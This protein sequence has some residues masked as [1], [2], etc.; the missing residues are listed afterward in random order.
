[1]I[2]RGVLALLAFHAGAIPLLLSRR[3]LEQ[4]EHPKILFATATAIA[5]AAI[6]LGAAA[7]RRAGRSPEGGQGPGIARDPLALG[8]L[9][10]LA[11]ASASA[12]ASEAPRMSTLGA[13]PSWHGV[14]T[15]AAYAALFFATRAVVAGPRSAR[16]LLF[17]PVAA[18]GAVAVHGILE[19][20]GA[21]PL[22][23]PLFER[24]ADVPRAAG[25]LGN[26]TFL[27]G[28]LAAALP[29]A[30]YLAWHALE[31]R[32]RGAAAVVGVVALLSLAALA[33]SFSRGP[34]LAAG[35]ALTLLGV[36]AW[37]AGERRGARALVVS[38]A[39]CVALLAAIAAASGLLRPALEQAALRV[40]RLAT[41]AAEV[42][43]LLWATSARVFLDHPVLGTGPDALHLAFPRYASAELWAREP[44]RDATRAHNEILHVAATQGTVGLLALG[45]AVAGL[46]G[47]AR[48]ASRAAAP[49]E[50]I[51]VVSVAASLLA[52]GVHG[53][54]GFTVAA[55][56]SLFALGAGIL[57]GLARPAP[58]PDVA[59]SPATLAAVLAA[60]A[61][62][63]AAALLHSARADAPLA[64]S[65]LGPALAAGVALAAR[66]VAREATPTD[67][68][69]RAI[70]VPAR[71]P[72]AADAGSRARRGGLRL[73]DAAIG[74]GAA[75]ALLELVLFPLSASR[76]ARGGADLAAAGRPDAAVAR[77]ERA[78]ALE[79]DEPAY[80]AQLGS[81]YYDL[82]LRT[83]ALPLRRETFERALR[84]FE[85]ELALAPGSTTASAN[86]AR[87]LAELAYLGAP[88]APAERVYAVYD[89]AI[90][91]A[92]GQ[93]RLAHDA[94]RTALV[95]GDVDRAESY[96][97]HALD[98]L[99]DFAPGR[100]QLAAAAARRGDLAR[101][102]RELR[103]A[104]EQRWFGERDAEAAARA[105]LARLH[106]AARKA[107]G[108]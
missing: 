65:L 108:R 1:M 26:A 50:R 84:A 67:P 68:P 47:T 63:G 75:V 55:I 29:L 104:L 85:R 34:W 39:A 13:Y 16:F 53:L 71:D 45:L 94:A 17:S 60:A 100:A 99:P 36:G 78:V 97:A 7:S 95:L 58:R 32:R 79:P 6:A 20:A 106:A 46:V 31:V 102:E 33:L 28:Y 52:V 35:A 9:A 105:D 64:A 66:E 4:F 57:S 5:L 87:A 76:I 51:L 10:L 83:P 21:G 96:A 72:R 24:A 42:R 90:A 22:P 37:R 81:A 25:P 59:P 86:V 89:R 80:R 101:A 38:L 82:A 8:A 3:M 73:A 15:F 40:G 18:A 92:P 12:A 74:A 2:R 61:A 30:A 98:A 93:I 103:T 54:F 70:G 77:L 107:A 23:A 11:S 14:L 62:I 88:D 41:P 43:T 49:S 19:S 56:G 27:G 69:R 48:R 91:R 44:D